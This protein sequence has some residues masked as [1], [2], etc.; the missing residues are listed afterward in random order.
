VVPSNAFST[1]ATAAGPWTLGPTPP[2]TPRAGAGITASFD[3]SR[4]Y[5]V[6]GL[7]FVDGSPS[8]IAFNDAWSIDASVC[9]Y[10]ANEKVCSGHGTANLD[11]VTCDCSGSAFFFFSARPLPPPCTHLP[12]HP[13]TP[14]PTLPSDWGGS[15]CD[16]CGPDAYGPNCDFCPL[17]TT[18]GFCNANKGWGVCDA[19]Q[20]CSCTGSHTGPDCGLCAVHTYGP[21]CAKCAACNYAHGTCSGDG[22]SSAYGTGKC[23][24]SDGW[25]GPA[26]N[27]PSPSGGGGGGGAAAA[28]SGVSPGTAFG[29]SLLVI[30]GVA[31][32]LALFPA[33]SVTVMGKQLFPGAA[34]RAGSAAAWDLAKRAAGALAQRA[35]SGGGSKETSSLLKS[36]AA[37]RSA[38]SPS[39]AA[40]RLKGAAVGA[41]VPTVFSAP[42]GGDAGG[43]AAYGSA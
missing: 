6:G 22:S 13:P 27:T 33:W 3:G 35:S 25:E 28:A 8:G 32:A 19:V 39:D 41:R 43:F 30:V 11:T 1:A 26:C 34:V 37:P 14:P 7:D 38:L 18:G 23:L 42:G 10:G 5:L 20:G 2:W 15:T 17:S 29:V 9:L 36:A 16:T 4:V 12:T 24:C 21:S 31:G 40:G